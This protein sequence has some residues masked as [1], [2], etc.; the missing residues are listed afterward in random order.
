M[1]DTLGAD[2]VVL[3]PGVSTRGLNGQ[4]LSALQARGAKVLETDPVVGLD[5]PDSILWNRHSDGSAFSYLFAPAQ[6]TPDLDPGSLELF[7]AA[8]A[9]DELRELLRRVAES[10]LAWDQVEIVT[11]DPDTYGSALHALS[12]QFGIPTTYA[13]GL[14]VERSR[15]GRVARAYLDWIEG[16][17]QASPIR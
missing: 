10:G 2:V 9:T 14:P 8:S 5:V 16:G 6:R 13:V 11:P 1:P 15:P 17:F 3:V 7:C 4:L 12:M